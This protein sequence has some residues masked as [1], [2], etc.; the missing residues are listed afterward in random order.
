MHSDKAIKLLVDRRVTTID[1]GGIP[2]TILEDPNYDPLQLNFQ[3]AFGDSMD[4]SKSLRKRTLL[5]F[6]LSG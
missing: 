5:P 4:K 2:E 6:L 1:Q 3:L